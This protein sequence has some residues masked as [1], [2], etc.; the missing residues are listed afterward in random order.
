MSNDT[1]NYTSD[2][3]QVYVYKYDMTFSQPKSLEF[4]KVKY[5]HLDEDERRALLRINIVSSEAVATINTLKLSL[6]L[7]HIRNEKRKRNSSVK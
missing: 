6:Q 7:L 1:R 5:V 3:L 2:H 4:M